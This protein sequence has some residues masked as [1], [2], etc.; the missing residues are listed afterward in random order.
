MIEM[1][2]TSSNLLQVI[3]KI[4]TCLRVFNNMQ[5]GLLVDDVIQR[6]IAEDNMMERERVERVERR[7]VTYMKQAAAHIAAV[8]HK[9]HVCLW[10]GD[11]RCQHD[12]M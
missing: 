3:D 7:E 9:S 12:T 2:C 11:H 1:L 6:N 4:S 5:K 8:S 10:P